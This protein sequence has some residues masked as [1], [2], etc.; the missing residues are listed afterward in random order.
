MVWREEERRIFLFASPPVKGC[1][2]CRLSFVDERISH[3]SMEQILFF[4]DPFSWSK[5]SCASRR[6]TRCQKFC[7]EDDSCTLN[8]LLLVKDRRPTAA[9]GSR[10]DKVSTVN[11]WLSLLFDHKP[12]LFSGLKNRTVLHCTA[13]LSII[14]IWTPCTRM[15]GRSNPSVLTPR[16]FV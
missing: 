7:S 3:F 8:S 16:R 9:Y 14:E 15:P 4:F 12:L 2:E 1:L 11:A 6:C 10:L 5:S 13:H